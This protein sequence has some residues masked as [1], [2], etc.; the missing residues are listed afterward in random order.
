MRECGVHDDGINEVFVVGQVCLADADGYV[1]GAELVAAVFG[2]VDIIERNFTLD[3]RRE[4][5]VD[6]SADGEVCRKVSCEILVVDEVVEVRLDAG[7][8]EAVQIQ[9]DVEIVCCHVGID[10]HGKVAA[11]SKSQADIDASCVVFQVYCRDVD[12]EILDVEFGTDFCVL[13]NNVALFKDDIAEAQLDGEAGCDFGC[14]LVAVVLGLFLFGVLGI[15]DAVLPCEVL[16]DVC[17]I[18]PFAVLLDADVKRLHV[19]IANV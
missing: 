4:D 9:V 6:V 5:A 11:V 10:L 16:Q 3:I 18:E 2:E 14:A 8:C 17:E 13:I 15:V 1:F 19:D 7:Q 12:R